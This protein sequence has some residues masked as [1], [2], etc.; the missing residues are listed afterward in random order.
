MNTSAPGES[1]IACNV[2]VNVNVDSIHMG[3]YETSLPLVV[4][5]HHP[6]Q[7]QQQQQQQ[8]AAAAIVPILT[9]VPNT[10]EP[11]TNDHSNDSRNCNDGNDPN[12][13]AMTYATALANAQGQVGQVAHYGSSNNDMNDDDDDD[14]NHANISSNMTNN[15][16]NSNNNNNT[17]DNNTIVRYTHQQHNNS[18]AAYVAATANMVNHPHHPMHSP[19]MA[20][21][22]ATQPTNSNHSV[23]VSHMAASVLDAA[24]VAATAATKYSTLDYLSHHQNNE[25]MNAVDEDGL[26]IA[27][28]HSMRP[29]ECGLTME[30]G[31]SLLEKIRPAFEADDRV[32]SMPSEGRMKRGHKI[33]KENDKK[34]LRKLLNKTPNELF[35]L[36]WVTREAVEGRNKGKVEGVI[37]IVR[38]NGYKLWVNGKGIQGRQQDAKTKCVNSKIMVHLCKTYVDRDFDR[39]SVFEQGVAL[40]SRLVD[41]Y[42]R[43]VDSKKK[44]KHENMSQVL[45]S[46]KHTSEKIL[47]YMKT[48]NNKVL[49]RTKIPAATENGVIANAASADIVALRESLMRELKSDSKLKLELLEKET[50][51]LVKIEERVTAENDTTRDKTIQNYQHFVNSVKEQIVAAAIRIK[52][53]EKRLEAIDKKMDKELAIESSLHLA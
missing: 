44:R 50:E 25:Y 22:T 2:N 19:Q 41:Q 23:S 48:N 4:N 28:P 29:P 7:Q 14:D 24:A 53:T 51:Y 37:A 39:F 32:L 3:S 49:A 43:Q 6:P 13:E 21:V 30:E 34:K 45:D 27:D 33:W 40:S 20:T 42:K 1:S 38:L 36:A 9:N 5:H 8:E 46:V 10:Q 47:E 16:C 52:S 11:N 15:A 18:N 35:E 31:L 12:N 26:L 17:H